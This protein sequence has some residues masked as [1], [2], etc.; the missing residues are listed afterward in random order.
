MALE[1]VFNVGNTGDNQYPSGVF[2]DDIRLQA[3]PV[4]IPPT[5]LMLASGLIGLVVIQRKK[6]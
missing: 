4:P 5:V 3:N 2:L 1:I 6:S